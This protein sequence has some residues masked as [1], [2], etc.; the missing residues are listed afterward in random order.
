M[1]E[2]LP[3]AREYGYAGEADDSCLDALLD[4][5]QL[6]AVRPHT[7][8]TGHAQ[9]TAALRPSS[10]AVVQ[11]QAPGWAVTT[12]MH[13]ALDLDEWG[14]WLLTAMDDAPSEAELAA[15]L[16]SRLDAAGIGFA[17]EQPA[18][19]VAHYLALFRRHGLLDN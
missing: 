17:P 13:Q 2:A 18:Q 4:A 11:A 15:R 8:G 9:A 12:C 5:V 14:R 3:L 6:H 10:L 19:W 7:R 1:G 16:A